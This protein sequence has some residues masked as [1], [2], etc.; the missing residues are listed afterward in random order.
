M[1]AHELAKACAIEVA[2]ATLKTFSSQGSTFLTKRFDRGPYNTR[3]H[4][5]SALSLLGKQDGDK[6]ASYL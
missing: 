2:P 1:V 6:N 4:F 3:L 5:A